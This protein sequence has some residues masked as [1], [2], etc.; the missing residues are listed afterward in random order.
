MDQGTIKVELTS[1]SE[2]SAE[3]TQ[4]RL[5]DEG[6]G[7][8]SDILK[9]IFDPFF[10]TKRNTG[11][12]GLGLSITKGIIEKHN[13]VIRIDSELGVGTMVNITLPAQ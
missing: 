12:T 4:I 7:I 8:P 11:G 6:P 1:I 3:L 13:G 2:N 10:T 5:T 9:K